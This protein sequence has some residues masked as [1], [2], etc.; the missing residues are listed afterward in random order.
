MKDTALVA[1]ERVALVTGAS[2]GFGVRIAVKLAERGYRVAASM[3]DP[4]SRGEELESRAKRAGVWNRIVVLRLDVTES[5][6]IEAAVSFL[7]KEYGRIDVLVNNAGY[8]AGGFTEEVPLEEWRLQMET[9][10]FGLVAVT[11]A[12]LPGMRQRRSGRIINMGS[13]SGRTAF[14]GFGP[15]ASSKFALEGF[16]ESLRHEMSPWG[17]QVVLIEPGSYRTAIW[18]KGMDTVSAVPDSP[19]RRQLDAVLAFTKRSAAGAPD[20]Q[21][22]ADLVGRLVDLRSPKLRYAPGRAARLLPSVKSLLP[23][24]LYERLVRF[25][26]RRRTP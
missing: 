18:E 12:V 14:P 17:I 13:V 15:Y 8:A 16:S 2:S 7:L 20:P 1:E 21:E 22:V 19:Y 9:N 26:L 25:A 10:F 4:V 11:R 5:G 3:R 24:R 23:W 6:S